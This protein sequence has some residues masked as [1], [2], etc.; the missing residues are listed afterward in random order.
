MR[1]KIIIPSII[2]V[3]IVAWL[4]VAGF[5]TVGAG[6][7]GV[8]IHYGQVD[9]SVIMQEGMHII[10][11]ISDNIISMDIRTLADAQQATAASADLQDVTTQLTINYHLDQNFVNIVYEKLGPAYA[12]S[13]ITPAIQ[14][15]VKAVSA[16]FTASQLVTERDMVKQQIQNAIS[17]RLAQYHIIVDAVSITN[18]Q[19]SPTFTQAIEAKVVAV[20]Q[21]EKATNELVTVK[22]EA[23]KAVA[24]ANGTAQSIGL[25]EKQLANSPHYIQYLQTTKW[26]GVLPKVTGGAIPFFDVNST[27]K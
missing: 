22:I 14:E 21:A 6:T 15:T 17:T 11:P 7:R 5:R 23:Q 2:V 16:K 8:L 26:D 25:V 20:Q 1:Y 19:F 3:I 12:D 4:A 10:N 27:K 18:F 13:I 9:E 24:Q